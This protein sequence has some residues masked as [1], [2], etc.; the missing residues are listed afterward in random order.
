MG[1]IHGFRLRFS[2]EHQSIDIHR[3]RTSGS[4][5]ASLMKQDIGFFDVTQIGELTSRMTQDCQQV[6]DQAYLNV[7]LGDPVGNSPGKNSGTTA[8]ICWCFW[9]YPK[10]QEWY[11]LFVFLFGG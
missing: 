6:V 11:C 7:M 5:F 1:K 2:L 3:G 4:L 9:R 8:K 10:E